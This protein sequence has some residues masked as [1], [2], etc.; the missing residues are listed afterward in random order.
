MKVAKKIDQEAAIALFLERAREWKAQALTGRQV[1]PELVAFYADFWIAGTDRV[2]EGDRLLFQWGN[3]RQLLLDEPTDLRGRGGALTQDQY[4]TEELP[5][6]N[7]TRQIV[8]AESDDVALQLS[9]TLSY[10]LPPLPVRGRHLWIP[11]LEEIDLLVG[12]YLLVPEIA[13]LL[14]RVPSSTVALVHGA[15]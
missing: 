2:E 13:D 8:P 10:E 9:L 14:E 7:F 3:S 1:V 4:T 12:D 5:Y 11:G 6:L 15:G